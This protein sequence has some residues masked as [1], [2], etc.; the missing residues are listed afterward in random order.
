MA[1][2]FKKDWNRIRIIDEGYFL[3]ADVEYPK[4]LFNLHRELPFLPE[5][6]K[7]GNGI[8]LFVTFITKKAMFFT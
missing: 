3:E 5:R 4:N 2:L 8:S 6:K 7:I 1:S